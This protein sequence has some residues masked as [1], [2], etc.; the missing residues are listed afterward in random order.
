MTVFRWPSD[1]DPF[2]GFRTMQRE[3][4]RLVRRG[5]LSESRGVGGGVYPPINVYNSPDEILV[6]CEIP[7]VRRDDLDLSITG[8]TLVVKGKKNPPI[9][10]REDSSVR[11][12]RRERGAGDF[13][14]TI[15]LPEHVDSDR[16][17]ASLKDGIL[18]VRL[19]KSEQAQPKRICVS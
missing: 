6:E 12:Q 16:I 9:E 17:A 19:P 18:S 10:E 7:G 15:V 3:L 4:E 13:S 8:E 1:W 11:Y 2:A 5:S 14:R